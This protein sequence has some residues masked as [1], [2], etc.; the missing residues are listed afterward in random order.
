MPQDKNDMQLI[1]L[2]VYNM[3][4]PVKVVR[5][6][7]ALYRDAAALITQTMNTYAALS[8]GAKSDKELAYMALIE[9]ALRYEKE[10]LRNDT[11]PYSDILTR[12][13]SELEEALKPKEE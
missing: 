12:L 2:H 9:I 4:M 6:E 3:E 10:V 7:E 8:K 13:T 5:E 1:K 11:K